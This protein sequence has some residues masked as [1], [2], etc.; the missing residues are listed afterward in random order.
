VTTIRNPDSR[1]L[2]TPGKSVD[3]HLAVFRRRAKALEDSRIIL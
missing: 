3:R 1:Q 2:S